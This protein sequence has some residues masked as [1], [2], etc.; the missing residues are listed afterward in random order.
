[1]SLLVKSLKQAYFL[2]MKDL[3]N[4]HKWPLFVYYFSEKTGTR[5]AQLCPYPY[6][7]EIIR[8]DDPV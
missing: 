4:N 6:P 8:M 7:F 1:M 5:V 3:S 2:I